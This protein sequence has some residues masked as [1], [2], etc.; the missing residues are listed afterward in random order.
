M[1]R[2]KKYKQTAEVNQNT[3]SNYNSKKNTHIQINDLIGW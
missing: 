1:S 2:L 3:K